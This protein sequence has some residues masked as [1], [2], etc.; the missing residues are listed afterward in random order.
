M[1]A[2]APISSL[3]EV[4]GSALRVIRCCCRDS[5]SS[6]RA[7]SM[8]QRIQTILDDDID[9]GPA[10]VTIKFSYQ[11]TQ[12]EID[13]SKENEQKLIAALEPFTS[14]ARRIG[15]GRRSSTKAP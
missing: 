4:A 5:S 13:L 14:R 8:A 11:G 9:G 2:V 10:D 3:V 12:Y 1:C 15:G 6:R 7:Q